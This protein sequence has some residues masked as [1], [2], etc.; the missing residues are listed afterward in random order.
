VSKVC[1][2]TVRDE[3]FCNVL[4]LTPP[5]AQ[6]LSNKFALMVEGAFFMPL[7]KLGRWDGKVRFFEE[8]TGKIY[9]RLLDDVVPYLESWG[10]DINLVDTRAP[11]KQITE[12]MDKDWFIRKQPE[13]ALRVELRDYQV[14][15]VNCCL[16]AQSGFV[17]AATGSGKTWMV[18]ALCDIMNRADIKTL[19]IVP[20]DDLVVQTA[21]TLRLGLLDVG[22][23]SGS[24]KDIYH[25]T[26]IATWQAL[27]NNPSL[28]NEF[29]CVIVD[30]A[31]G[32]KAKV[33]GDLINVHG[34]AIAYR[35]GFTGTMPK[36]EID[37]MTLK[38]SIG[39]TLFSIT[40]AELMERGYLAQLE[41]EPVEIEDD[42]DEEFPDYSSEKAFLNRSPDRLD[43]LADLII[44]KAAQYGNTLVLVNSV[45]Q[46]KELQ[47]LIKDSVFLYGADDTDV[48]AEWYS[49]FEKRDDL[50]VIATFGIASTGISI[51]RIF[52]EI[53][54]DA[55]KAFIRCIQSIGRGLRKGHD[56]ERVHLV[57][58]HSKLKWSKKHF[59]ERNKYYKE[60]KY[61]VSKLVKYKL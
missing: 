60:A 17:L 41:I 29:K 9:H 28:M 6:F 15:A 11:V 53:M 47:K 40:A 16:N 25:E 50:I 4:G 35:F 34:K 10:Y 18:A 56:K 33:V 61:P 31:H 27:Q 5:D 39:E 48:R 59:R 57:D 37:K 51:D 24:T 44:A 43:F 3:V 7:Y 8:K 30:E 55:G 38:G 1:N 42:V 26:V 19:V 46:G 20:S 12:R 58:V 23:Y 49:M 54:I 45:K 22:I 14:E 2:I 13:M 52:C 21:A 36:P 32:A